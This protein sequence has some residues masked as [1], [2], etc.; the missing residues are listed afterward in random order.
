MV[1]VYGATGPQKTQHLCRTNQNRA[2]GSVI[3]KLRKLFRTK[4]MPF[5]SVAIGVALLLL[6]LMIRFKTQRLYCP[7]S[8]SPGGRSSIGNADRQSDCLR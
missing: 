2:T 5:L 1:S 8:R 4:T 6:L 3:R 7:D